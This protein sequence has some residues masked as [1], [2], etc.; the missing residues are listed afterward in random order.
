MR[1]SSVSVV[2]GTPVPRGRPRKA[3]GPRQ[4]RDRAGPSQMVP[5]DRVRTGSA[6]ADERARAVP[7]RRRRRGRVYRQRL[8]PQ[9]PRLAPPGPGHRA[10]QA[11]LRRE[12]PQP[13][14]G[15]PGPPLRLRARRTSATTTPSPGPSRARTPPF[16][17]AG[18]T[19]RRPFH[20][21]PGHLRADQPPGPQ[22]PP[23]GGRT[24]G[25]RRFLQ[26][27]CYDT[28]GLRVHA[29]HGLKRYDEVQVGDRVLTINQ[30]TRQI[31]EKAVEKVIVQDYRG[32]M[33]AF[34]NNRIDLLVTPKSPGCCIPTGA[35]RRPRFT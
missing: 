28:A 12:P 1:T 18:E 26:V 15:A 33:I 7:R 24:A 21:R 13:R 3:G 4:G 11:D 32:P 25:L 35:I 23:P 31:E 20:P 27:S 19:P 6:K 29:K 22:H 10:G 2:I 16:S 14:P 5:S 30:E 34:R 9:L 8:R 17:F